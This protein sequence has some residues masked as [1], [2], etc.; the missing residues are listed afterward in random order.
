V[1]SNAACP[2]DDIGYHLLDASFPLSKPPLEHIE[3]KVDARL[4]DDYAGNYQLGPKLIITVSRDGDHLFTQSTVRGKTEIF[5]ESDRDYFF[6]VA[7]VQFTFV[8][9]DDGRA[10]EM[11]VHQ[12][13]ESYHAKR[14]E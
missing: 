7:D 10:I 11:I 3:I 8:T 13:G 12:N 9:G 1:L 2:V 5:P 6:K 14:V 4:F